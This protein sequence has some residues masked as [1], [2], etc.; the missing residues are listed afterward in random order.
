MSLLLDALKR[1]AEKK[2]K[3]A[4]EAE[5]ELSLK[6]DDARI[7][8][9][10]ET[11]L[12]LGEDDT[13]LSKMHSEISA[14]DETQIIANNAET[15][16]DSYERSEVPDDDSDDTY[17]APNLD[18]DDTVL[19]G[20]HP[21]AAGQQEGGEETNLNTYYASDETVSRVQLPVEEER[22]SDDETQIIESNVEAE[23]ESYERSEV[24]DDDS[25]DTYLAPNLDE[26]DTVL[27]GYHPDAA[28]Q[29]EG[30][31]ETNLNTYY[32]S[33]ETV[34]R[35][36]LPV[37]EERASDD[38]TQI[39]ESK[40]E[41]EVES[42][43]R[44]EVPDDDSDDTY[45]A[46]NLDEDDTVLAG[47]HPDATGQQE[48]GEETNLNT[49]Y[50]SDETVSRVRIPVE[51]ERLSEDD[52]QIIASKT[53]TDE[54]D[55]SDDTYLPAD[56]EVE[57]TS[58]DD[59]N[60]TAR[61]TDDD[62]QLA[63]QQGD[64]DSVHF[65]S[66]KTKAETDTRD[67][68]NLTGT[69]FQDATDSRT[70]EAS[71]IDTSED[72]ELPGLGSDESVSQLSN[73]DVSD[74][75]GRADESQNRSENEDQADVESK[76][77]SASALFEDEPQ[78]DT[79][80]NS[81]GKSTAE[82]SGATNVQILAD[83]ESDTTAELG[84]V[85][86]TQRKDDQTSVGDPT[87]TTDDPAS[88]PGVD[89]DLLKNERTIVRADATSTHTYAPDN[90]DRTLIKPPTED[91]SRIFAGMRS[92]EDV[93]MTPDYA[94]RVF[95]SKSSANRA[96]HYKVYAG[97]ATSILLAIGIFS[98][99][100]L[101]DEYND[102]DLALMPLKRDPM[103]G[104]LKN[105]NS[106]KLTN[107]FEDK[108]EADVDSRTLKIV[109]EAADAPIVNTETSSDS[110]NEAESSSSQQSSSGPEPEAAI[111]ENKAET[112][113]QNIQP[114]EK[115]E[116]E[117]E[118]VV[119]AV[120]TTQQSVTQ[121]T[122]EADVPTPTG[123]TLKI[124]ANT[125]IADK[126]VWLKQAYQAYQRGDDEAALLKYNQVLD[127]DPENRN[128]LLARAAIAIQNGDS[129]SAIKDYQTLLVANPKDSLAM[130]SLISTT[131]I[132][133]QKSETQLKL[134]IRDEPD[135]PYLNFVL[136][137]IYGTQNRWQEAQSLYFKALENNPNDPNYA[138]NLAVS[139]EHIE[140]PK[141]AIS[142]YE[143]ALLNMDRGLAT[144]NKDVVDRRLEVLRRL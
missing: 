2:A 22:A 108:P 10:A 122:D 6:S 95:L 51:E 124:S 96:H 75:L 27:A 71:E 66:K 128:A 36:Q 1:A 115:V 9:D 85:D 113:V 13:E 140:K 12:G 67:D 91:A 104:L 57:S 79:L 127:I 64:E 23:V 33:D 56:G 141:V 135:S 53:A 19:A 111:T 94:K 3:Q 121:K 82:E 81:V 65:Q 137:N 20:Y 88:D 116:E 105:K 31:E 89:L 99:F 118:A 80:E 43:E 138:Y 84:L 18:E 142:Y 97:I 107:L 68:T 132:S 44:S 134:M 61:D 114:V 131:S 63:P 143:K 55:D 47:Y 25:D 35:V 83:E 109:Q 129:V 34:S 70:E 8:A 42:Y 93:L 86:L 37:E 139:L 45:L 17:L 130:S 90:Y 49:Y 74:F 87:I 77:V 78:D 50:A 136:A 126:D 102:I 123:K 125:K 144:F 62:T 4:E 16:V 69:A 120:E 110:G 24:V 15:E 38:E 117:S 40:A 30:G 60:L 72:T 39:I 29:Q 46:P 73:D 48:G 58:A 101:Q 54:A 14:D 106:E 28:G 76:K 98:L 21:D 133:P 112:E 52:T 7:S 59:T 5:R 92:E 100:E 103:P 32:A 119:I 26:D 41:A 11:D